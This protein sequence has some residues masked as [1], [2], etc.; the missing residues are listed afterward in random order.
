M[1]D[2]INKLGDVKK[3]IDEI[4]VKLDAITVE[5]DAG[6]GAVKVFVTANRKV[7]SIEI[8]DELLKV[9]SKE[10]LQELLE[11]ALNHALENAENVSESEMKAAGKDFLP[12]F[13]GF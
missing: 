6:N 10:E 4:K 9:E 3:K 11:T 8:K 12:G 2:M 7:K 1:F 13:P 5:G